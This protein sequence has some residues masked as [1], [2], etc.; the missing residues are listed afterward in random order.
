MIRAREMPFSADIVG[1]ADRRDPVE[2]DA[3]LQG[4][5]GGVVTGPEGEHQDEFDQG[6]RQ[7]GPA[8]EGRPPTRQ[9]QNQQR[10]GEGE[11]E[12][13]TEHNYFPLVLWERFGRVLTH[14]WNRP[15]PRQ[16]RIIQPGLWAL[17]PAP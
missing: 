3:P 1:G 16:C 4:R 5:A 17:H 10:G 14:G 7:G 15:V 12:D 6:R 2:G 9:Q 11:E 13:D 8:D